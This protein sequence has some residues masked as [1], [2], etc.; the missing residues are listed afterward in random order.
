MSPQSTAAPDEQLVADV[1]SILE[2]SNADLINSVQ[3]KD[4]PE[5]Q[6]C[7]D[8]GHFAVYR[9]AQHVV[10][11]LLRR[12]ALP[13][14]ASGNAC[15]RLCW[16]VEKCTKTPRLSRWAFS[17]SCYSSLLSFYVECNEHDPHRS[18][19][20]V[21]DLLFRM[22]SKNPEPPV[23]LDT[24]KA[25]LRS[26]FD[27]ISGKSIHPAAKSA[28]KV[29]DHL[30]CKNAVSLPDVAAAYSDTSP[31]LTLSDPLALW[32][33]FALALFRWMEVHHVCPVAGKMVVTTIMGLHRN[34]HLALAA[35]HP[36]G[37]AISTWLA[38]LQE[39]I[40]A[41]P[42]LL[43]SVKTY[44]FTPMFRADRDLSLRFLETLSR[45]E[46]ETT[47]NARQ[48]DVPALLQLAALEA[49]KKMALVEEPAR[50]AGAALFSASKGVIILPETVVRGVLKHPS[51]RVR[52]LALSLLVSS[53]ATTRPYSQVSFDL[54]RDHLPGFHAD[55]NA[56][57]R[58]E[59]LSHSK[60]MVRRI[61]GAM[62][63]LCKTID[64]LQ[65]AWQK[66]A[67]K[68]CGSDSHS[69]S[70]L[71][72]SKD[73]EVE[74]SLASLREHDR[75]FHW[76]L[77]FLMKELVP[78]ASYQRHFSALKAVHFV[79]KSE[80]GDTQRTDLGTEGGT[81]LPAALASIGASWYRLL[82][83][84]LMDPFDD[85]REAAT[86][87]LGLLP[88]EVVAQI[89]RRQN[90][91]RS[92][93]G[94]SARDE[95]RNLRTKA[96]KMAS[97]TGR[98]DHADGVAKATELS[99]I[100][101]VDGGSRFNLVRDMLDSLDCRLDI[102]HADLG[103][104]VLDAPVHGIFSSLC[105]LWRLASRSRYDTMERE[106]LDRIQERMVYL[107]RRAWEIVKHV[108]CD[109]SPEGHFPHD[110][111]QVDGLDTK[112]L[113]SYSFRAVHESSNLLRTLVS[114]LKPGQ[115]SSAISPSRHVFEDI[116]NLAF[117]QLAELRHRGAFTTVSHTFTTCCQNFMHLPPAESSNPGNADSK[118][119]LDIWYQGA[120]DCI[121][122]QVST[123]RRSA[124]IPALL[125][126]ILSAQAQRPSFDNVLS[127][128]Q[129]VGSEEAR[130]AEMDGSNLP[131]V[132]ALNCIKEV[133]KSSLLRQRA[134]PYLAR[135]LQLAAHS[136]RSEVWAIR[137]CGLL[138]LRSLIDCVFGTSDS[139]AEMESGWDGKTNRVSV[140]R[141][142]TLPSVLRDLLLPIRSEEERRAAPSSAKKVFPALDII[143]RAGPPKSIRGELFGLISEYLASPIWHVREIAARTLCS[144]FMHDGWPAGICALGRDSRSST[145]RAHGI[146]LTAKFLL[147]RLPEYLL[148]KNIDALPHMLSTLEMG[149][150]EE[151]KRCPEVRA[152]LL[153]VLNTAS[154]HQISRGLGVSSLVETRTVGGKEGLVSPALLRSRIYLSQLY[155][156]ASNTDAT[157]L[158]A[159]V[160]AAIREDDDA[161]LLVIEWT[162]RIWGGVETEETAMGL[163]DVYSKAVM[164][165]LNPDVRSTALEALADVMDSL[166]LFRRHGTSGSSPSSQLEVLWTCISASWTTP[167]LATAS[168]RA[169]GPILGAIATRCAANSPSW[170]VTQKAI[171]AWGAMMQTFGAEDKAFDTRLAAA[172]SLGSFFSCIQTCHSGAMLLPQLALYDAMND[173]DVEVREV[174]AL[175]AAPLVGGIFAPIEAATALLRDLLEKCGP[176]AEFKA[177]VANRIV[178]SMRLSSFQEANDWAPAANQLAQAMPADLSLF[179]IEEQNLYVDEV[180]ETQRWTAVLDQLT[181]D[182]QDP[183]LEALQIWTSAGL[184]EIIRLART[185][186]DGPL[187][188]TSKP[189]VFAICTCI[190][191]AAASLAK[192]PT[193]ARLKAKL[194]AFRQVAEEKDVHGLLVSM[195][196]GK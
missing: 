181:F 149:T 190:I 170:E 179:V 5:R 118:T 15:L 97:L 9:A 138:L 188:W 74:E 176:L 2:K 82:C 72:E 185:E 175:A 134:E 90:L 89:L 86:A 108:L 161:A 62:N 63:M 157:K 131:Q 35:S 115:P 143:R 27:I 1:D 56:K 154:S 141:Y 106:A 42:D 80:Q 122:E 73:R 95:G 40:S 50:N 196:S 70:S 103:A 145:N 17:P 116:G 28:L 125:V 164:T 64:R 54:L 112:D 79:L 114:N 92:T 139:K 60:D 140:S 21:L 41:N 152:A 191:L 178:G 45:R 159:I 65:K 113:L 155:L 19:K 66:L 169:S 117:S 180:R 6:G 102:A 25:T 111:E 34:H 195:A 135:C 171:P 126:G 88:L 194:A 52:S 46:P 37:F 99:C 105:G 160:E 13:K 173:D 61:K 43:E 78:T 146:L 48:L 136:L 156:A 163:F 33:S 23:A 59:L 26:L 81:K 121:F 151:N 55:P 148:E 68:V 158:G 127:K 123:T 187:G 142:D 109:D 53:V 87:T 107:S 83:D 100:W 29:L 22:L 172:K 101:Y 91:A 130:A 137:N 7:A 98:A 144:F 168:I 84:L 104:A 147:E 85:V 32:R 94:A 184:D 77:D 44:I 124:G 120:L 183:A 150:A 71:A 8:W 30:V 167:A 189:S 129:Q 36:E 128:L 51:P 133:F 58:H 166:T 186:E 165:S 18:M 69:S 93:D 119:L 110:L 39:C 16:F 96:D 20:L 153:E 182:A 192:L 38:W 67:T 10:S 3:A 31:R 177:Q 12:A 14:H 57:L 162:S 11:E 49:G 4:E 174:A 132:H 47:L 24:K 193:G 76:Y 75:F